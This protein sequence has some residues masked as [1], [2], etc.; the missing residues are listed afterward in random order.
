MCQAWQQVYGKGPADQMDKGEL[1]RGSQH[2]DVML[3]LPILQ[4]SALV[5]ICTLA[6][7]TYKILSTTEI[8]ISSQTLQ[9]ILR[10]AR[11]F[12]QIMQ[13][14]NSTCRSLAHIF[15]LCI[16]AIFF[17]T[18]CESEGIQ[19]Y[20]KPYRCNPTENMMVPVMDLH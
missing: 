5:F 16:D 13:L 6:Y 19:R 8:A 20:S 12:P 9:S 2:R 15:L 10:E 11:I 1:Q 18:D 3:I 4:H 17:I 7:I 14:G